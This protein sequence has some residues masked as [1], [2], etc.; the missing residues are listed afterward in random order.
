MMGPPLVSVVTPLHNGEKYLA[1]CIRSVLSQT[2]ENWEYIIV[3]NKSTDRSAQVMA[4]YAAGERRIKARE[5]EKFLSALENHNRAF[6]LISPEGKYCKV[7]HADDWLYP[8]CL[9]KMV[10]LAEE[11]EA[12]SLVGSYALEGDYVRFDGLP[13]EKRIVSGREVCR[14]SLLGGPYVFGSPTTLLFRS[15]VVRGKE[16]FYDEGHLHADE[17]ACYEALRGGA[18]FGF[19]HQVLAYSRVHDGRESSKAEKFNAYITGGLDIF[20]KYGPVYLG[21][22]EFE[23]TGKRKLKAYYRF[24]AESLI[25]GREK[26]FWHFHRSEL[27]KMGMA[28]SGMRLAGETA[29]LA[30]LK[31]LD[32]KANLKTIKRMISLI[33]SLVIGCT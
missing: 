29:I 23:S 33:N 22:E 20:R 7:V 10:A 1:E 14:R 6:R 13:Y 27:K 21:P 3:N 15:D 25:E 32:I 8:D 31:L 26:E 9:E 11:D 2:Y 19:V 4:R 16:K 18:K 24:L 28:L 12:V 30:G 17:E 5:N